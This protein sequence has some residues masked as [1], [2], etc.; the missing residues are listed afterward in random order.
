MNEKLDDVEQRFERLT[1]DL[2]NPAVI[3]DSTRLRSL[4]RERA[5]IEKLVETYRTYKKVLVDLR[6]N[7]ELLEQGDAEL[8]AMAKDELPR[9]PR[10]PRRAGGR[11]QAAPAPERSQR[12]QERDH[13]VPRG[14]GR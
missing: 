9:P 1:A 5:S 10:P 2:S 11:A 4:S 3:A 12:R 14:G 6:G 8:K 7:E 13:R